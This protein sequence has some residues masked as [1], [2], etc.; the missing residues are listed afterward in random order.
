MSALALIVTGGDLLAI[1]IIGSLF[2]I[3][4]VVIV[5]LASRKPR[6]PAP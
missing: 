1:G 2:V 3:T 6:P 4:A 5:V